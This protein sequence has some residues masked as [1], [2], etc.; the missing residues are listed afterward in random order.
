MPTSATGHGT[1]RCWPATPRRATVRARDEGP[2]GDGVTTVGEIA[3]LL[4]RA[5]GPGESA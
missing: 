1:A 2:S 5:A 4:E 3:A